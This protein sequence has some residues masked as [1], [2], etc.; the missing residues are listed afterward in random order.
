M[1]CSRPPT[2]RLRTSPAEPSAAAAGEDIQPAGD[3]GRGSLDQA[4]GAE[5][6]GSDARQ[7]PGRAHGAG[8]RVLGRRSRPPLRGLDRGSWVDAHGLGRGAGSGQQRAH[9]REPSP[10][11]PEHRL[12]APGVVAPAK[13]PAGERRAAARR[14]SR[15]RRPK[16]SASSE[17][18]TSRSSTASRIRSSVADNRRRSSS[19]SSPSRASLGVG[20]ARVCASAWRSC[21]TRS[22]RRP[23]AAAGGSTVE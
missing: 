15:E 13:Q 6:A 7:E 17:A 18:A 20:A 19:S 1:R 9:R 14:M 2:P 12:P 11:D 10:R 3:R 21:A 23:A 4:V 16:V 8:I 5:A 22:R